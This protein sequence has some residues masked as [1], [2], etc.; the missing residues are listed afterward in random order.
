[1]PQAGPQ[2]RMK[3]GV[4]PFIHEGSMGG[5][6][7]RYRDIQAMAQAAEAVGLDSFWLADH[8]ISAIA[9]RD[10]EKGVWEAF[11]F[12]SALAAVTTRITIGSLVACVSFRNPAMLAKMADSLDEISN[13][14]FILGL[15]AGWHEPEYTAF[16]YPYDHRV[17]RFEEALAI[18][19]PLLRDGRVD[20]EGK[21]YSARDCVLRPRGPSRSGPPIWI[22][23]KGP[24]MMRLV[25]KY[26]DAWNTVWHDRPE[27]VAAVLPKLTE[28]CAA[29]GRDPA[30]IE[31]TAGS[32]ARLVAPGEQSGADGASITGS[33]QEMAEAIRAFERVG[34]RH[35]VL[36]LA[37]CELQSV[38]RLGPVVELL[39]SQ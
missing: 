26:A 19:A 14:R 17:G 4:K 35:L 25:A 28:A 16:G 8:V 10:D 27:E 29:A 11:T 23:A 18:I 39:R 30:T 20:F 32:L 38:E 5:S 2:Q 31:L 33:P 3:L 7:P 36:N 13:G 21:Y 12:L 1:M 22:G 37:P 15:G 34:V 24:R 6:T 9:T